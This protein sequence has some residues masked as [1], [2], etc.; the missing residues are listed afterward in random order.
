MTVEEKGRLIIQKIREEKGKDPGEIFRHLAEQDFVSMH[1]PEHHILDGA[2]LLTACYNAGFRM[3]PDRALES[4]LKEGLRMPGA[5]CGLWGVCGAVTSVGAALAVMEG[6][7]PLSDDG[8]W[9]DHM[10]YTSLALKELGKTGG[11]RC[12]KRDAVIALKAAVP[13]IHRR[14]GIKL[15]FAEKECGFSARNPQC[16]RERCPFYPGRK[17]EGPFSLYT[18]S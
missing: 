15:D 12:C 10:E 11:P 4:L 8:S 1:G 16:I 9:G 7:G 14:F 6:T 18:E 5:M 13:Y 2:A 17:A 3:D